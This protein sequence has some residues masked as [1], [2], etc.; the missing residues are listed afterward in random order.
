M[1]STS[2][3][4]RHNCQLEGRDCTAIQLSIMSEKENRKALDTCE[5][6]NVVKF[7]NCLWNFMRKAVNEWRHSVN[8]VCW[9]AKTPCVVN[10]IL[11]MEKYA[12]MCI[13][14]II[15]ILSYCFSPHKSKVL[16][17]KHHR[18]AKNSTVQLIEILI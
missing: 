12:M 17:S 15:I 2:L 3:P 18:E 1:K 13:I 8:T 5:K 10:I 14:F 4:L 6:S 9:L 7:R 11:W 16:D